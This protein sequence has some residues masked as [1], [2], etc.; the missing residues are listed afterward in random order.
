MMLS[1]VTSSG[2]DEESEGSEEESEE[3]EGRK[4]LPPSTFVG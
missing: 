2:E 4:V 1:H 3:S